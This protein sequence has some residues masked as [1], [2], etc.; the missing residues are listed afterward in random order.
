MSAGVRSSVSIG[1]E[2]TPGTPVTPNKSIDVRAGDGIQTNVDLQT[3]PSI[4]G[5]L[6]KEQDAYKGN[7]SHEG[8]Y[9]FDFRPGYV[10]YFLKSLF[11]S[12][13]SVAKSAPN[14]AVYDHTF[15]ES[16]TAVALTVEQ[17]VDQIVR[18]YAGAFVTK[19]KLS[20]TTGENLMGSVDITAKSTASATAIT[21]AYET[22][23]AF[24]FADCL[25]TNGVTI[26]GT[27]YDEVQ[28]LELEI[29]CNGKYE[30]A[31]GSND[32]S[33]YYKG[34]FT[35]S[36]K[37]ELYMNADS[38]AKFTDYL[39]KTERAIE[40]A[41]TGDTIGSSSNYK[42]AVSVPRGLFEVATFA[43]REDYNLISISFKGIYDPTTSK[44]VSAVLTNITTNYN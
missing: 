23:R 27:A 9:E 31:M 35:V 29:D 19:L 10:G 34:G 14:A 16:E 6:A 43:I 28:K 20:C 11:G 18:R 1:L 2:T 4:R 12:V 39:N 24:N 30:H 36:G 22:V 7:Q 42:M 13:N 8:S 26:G 44:V 32:P 3:V 25:T 37:F 15:S 41:F 40:F 17:A 5:N 33:F 38:A 21:P